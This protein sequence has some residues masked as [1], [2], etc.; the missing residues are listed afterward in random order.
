MIHQSSKTSFLQPF[1]VRILC[2]SSCFHNYK[3]HRYS[4]HNLESSFLEIFLFC[5]PSRRRCSS[6]ANQ[7]HH[8]PN[9]I[10][11]HHLCSSN[12]SSP[13]ID[14]RDSLYFNGFQ[15]RFY[16]V[17]RAIRIMIRMDHEQLMFQPH[18]LYKNLLLR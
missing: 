11:I 16:L 10:I 14:W 1:L 3:H 18:D 9:I 4:I 8:P 13:H 15:L 6:V 12:F 7:Q 5:I 2:M 17:I